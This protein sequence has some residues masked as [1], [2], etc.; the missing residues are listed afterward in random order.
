MQ[1]HCQEQGELKHLPPHVIKWIGAGCVL[2]ESPSIAHV[3]SIEIKIQNNVQL[4]TR[5]TEFYRSLQLKHVKF[6]KKC[7]VTPVTLKVIVYWLM[8]QT[9]IAHTMKA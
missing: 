9:W 8:F 4:V 6:E 1:R 5:I 3:Q 2:S 7:L